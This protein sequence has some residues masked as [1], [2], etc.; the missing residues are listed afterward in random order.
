MQ[1]R[2]QHQESNETQIQGLPNF[3][4]KSYYEFS[5]KHYSG[6]IEYQRVGKQFADSENHVGIKPWQIVSAQISFKKNESRIS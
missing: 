4:I 2:L 5:G 1:N 6:L 3:M